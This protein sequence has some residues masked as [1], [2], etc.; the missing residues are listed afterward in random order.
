[1]YVSANH[2]YVKNVFDRYV[3]ILYFFVFSFMVCQCCA[4]AFDRI[5]HNSV[6]FK[7]QMKDIT[8]DRLNYIQKN[9]KRWGKMFRVTF[10]CPHKHGQNMS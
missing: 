7:L 10:F 8:A 5:G 9:N 4:Y 6:K 1:M 3:E 2:N